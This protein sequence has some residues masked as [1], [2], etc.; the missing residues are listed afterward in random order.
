[1][2]NYRFHRYPTISNKLE[3]FTSQRTLQIVWRHNQ[4]ISC[5]TPRMR[6]IP[7]VNEQTLIFLFIQWTQIQDDYIGHLDKCHYTISLP[8]NSD[9]R[10]EKYSTNVQSRRLTTYKIW[11]EGE[12]NNISTQ[13]HHHKRIIKGKVIKV[14]LCYRNISNYRATHSTS[15]FSS[16]FTSTLVIV[17]KKS[18]YK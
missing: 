13:Q 14:Y 9:R 15:H 12:K 10:F 18:K 8:M 4:F 2:T 16:L 11:N 5:K 3:N 6:N 1:M 7:R 17:Y